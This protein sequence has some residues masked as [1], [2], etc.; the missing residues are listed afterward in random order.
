MIRQF[1]EPIG[2]C[3]DKDLTNAEPTWLHFFVICLPHL[4][5]STLSVSM[6]YK[7]KYIQPG[8]YVFFCN[9]TKTFFFFKT[10][11]D[12]LSVKIQTEIRFWN[13]M[14]KG[15]GVFFLRSTVLHKSFNE[16]LN[17]FC[18][19]LHLGKYNFKLTYFEIDCNHPSISGAM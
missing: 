12:P 10:M 4:I 2:Y 16:K 8:G 3:G 11:F 5:W 6:L 17:P 9:I 15:T 13:C 7:L 18:L 19:R 14:S 1:D